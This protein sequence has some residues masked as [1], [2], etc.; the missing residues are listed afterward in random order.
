M[1]SLNRTELIGRLGKDPEVRSTSTGKQVASFSIA[2]DDSY[3]DATGNVVERTD[4]C[5]IVMWGGLAGVAEKY[6]RKG[7]QVYVAGRLQTRSYDDKSGQKHYVTEVIAKELIMLDG[8]K[9][10]AEQPVGG[11]VPAPA[12]DCPF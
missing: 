3:T 6:L 8:R 10:N 7:S 1:K 9:G 11:T 2:T 5:N 4:W 12:D